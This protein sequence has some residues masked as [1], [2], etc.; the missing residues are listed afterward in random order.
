[1]VTVYLHQIV[2]P[3]LWAT[4]NL[5]RV[6][7]YAYLVPWAYIP[8][9]PGGMNAFFVSLVPLLMKLVQY[10][11]V[12]VHQAIMYLIR[13]LHHVSPALREH[14]PMLQGVHCV[15]PANLGLSQIR[16]DPWNAL[17]VQQALMH[18]TRVHPHVIHAHME[19]SPMIQGV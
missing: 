7:M 10:H 4:I 2:S 14:F 16:T 5:Q 1:M 17:F 8:T 11:A 13:V 19:H 9:L 18:L 3:V 12:I 6:S 15:C